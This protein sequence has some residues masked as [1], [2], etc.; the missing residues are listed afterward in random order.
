MLKMPPRYGGIASLH[1]NDFRRAQRLLWDGDIPKHM[2]QG[3]ATWPAGS[4][5]DLGN[6]DGQP[7]ISDGGGREPSEKVES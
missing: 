2:A 5:S 3:L 7:G 6:A 1:I 4:G